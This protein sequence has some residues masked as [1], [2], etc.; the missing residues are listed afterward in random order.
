MKTITFEV[1]N[2]DGSISYET[3]QLVEL[4]MFSTVEELSAFID[5]AFD[6]IVVNNN[7]SDEDQLDMMNYESQFGLNG[8]HDHHNW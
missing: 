4:P 3:S 8:Y 2:D 5:S 7:F 6:K 1:Y